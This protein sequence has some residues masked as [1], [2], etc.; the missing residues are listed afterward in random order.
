MV[1]TVHDACLF[2]SCS[3]GSVFDM[4]VRDRVMEGCPE[5]TLKRTG[6]RRPTQQSG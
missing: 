2:L 3:V 6:A 1:S 4:T 5:K